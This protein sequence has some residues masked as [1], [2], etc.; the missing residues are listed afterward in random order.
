MSYVTNSS[1][2]PL[3]VRYMFYT[4]CVIFPDP[5]DDMPRPAKS[6]DKA[7]DL[8]LLEF[9]LIFRLSNLF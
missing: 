1:S 8:R 9:F 3:L 6:S 5:I 7:E 4:S 2:K